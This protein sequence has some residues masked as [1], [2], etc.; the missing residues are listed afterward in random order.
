MNNHNKKRW[1]LAPLG[2][3]LIGAGLS[4]AIDAGFRKWNHEDWF[5]YGTS[6]L[7]VFNSGIC[8]FGRAVAEYVWM[9]K[10]D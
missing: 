4:M 7:V 6:A 1:I 3:V 2:L 5:L 10:N 9:K 8:I